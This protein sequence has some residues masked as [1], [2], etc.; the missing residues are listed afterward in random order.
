MGVV[1]ENMQGLAGRLRKLHATLCTPP[2]GEVIAKICN[3][4]SEP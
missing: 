2:E 1:C 4:K 3:M